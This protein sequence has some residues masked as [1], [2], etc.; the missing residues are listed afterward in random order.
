MATIDAT[1]AVMTMFQ[2]AI[3]TE[4]GVQAVLDGKG[5]HLLDQF[6]QLMFAV[7]DVVANHAPRIKIAT[8]KPR[9]AEA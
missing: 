7:N 8:E 4:A 1:A 9:I 6:A 5:K 3:G 2:Q